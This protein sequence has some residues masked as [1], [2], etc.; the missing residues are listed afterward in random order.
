[1]FKLFRSLSFPRAMILLTFVGSAVT[2]WFVYKRT[3]ELRQLHE[4][5]QRVKLV[6]ASIQSKAQELDQLLSVANREGLKGD[7]LNDIET[8]IR[9]RASGP[10]INLGQVDFTP[11]TAEPLKGVEDLKYK[12][13][14]R[15]KTQRALRGSIANFLYT[16]EQDSRR[17]KVT[18]IKIDPFEKLK[19]G[20]LGSDYWTFET[21]I[22]S[23]R[24]KDGT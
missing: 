24:A 11:S 12:I 14:P 8:Y 21:E 9:T 16:L 5:N 13:R 4:D 22:T 1:M 18:S 3:S 7:I 15:E 2:G 23:R 10:N 20:Q 17:I 19:P 6:V